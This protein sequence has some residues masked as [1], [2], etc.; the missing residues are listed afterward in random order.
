MGVKAH[1]WGERRQR[2]RDDA[3]SETAPCP[4]CASQNHRVPA[5]VAGLHRGE[6]R[7]VSSTMSAGRAVHTAAFSPVAAAHAAPA[8]GEEQRRICSRPGGANTAEAPAHFL[9]P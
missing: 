1:G 6:T 8:G 4:C 9:D 5:F 2:R 3:G 7:L